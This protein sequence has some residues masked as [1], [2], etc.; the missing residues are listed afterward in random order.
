MSKMTA[1][2]LMAGLA[3]GL[4]VTP[5][6]AQSRPAADQLADLEI[7]AVAVADNGSV[8]Y[9]VAN[10]G[11]GGTDRPF[12]VDVYVDGVRRDSVTHSP[13]PPL[14]MQTVQSNRARLTECTA[15]T[16]RLVLDPQNGVREASKA[17]NERVARL[18]PP[19]AQP[20]RS[21]QP[22]GAR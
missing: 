12:V 16:V 19:C 13:L 15:G 1:R 11:T 20:S 21:A 5:A 2:L 22:A 9:Q 10:R 17:N 4:C 14:S 7:V 6:S 3:L 18:A 8:I